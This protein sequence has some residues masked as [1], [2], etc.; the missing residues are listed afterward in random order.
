VERS[1][2][3]DRL[4]KIVGAPN[5]AITDA[6]SASFA[7]RAA[8]TFTLGFQRGGSRCLRPD[9]HRD[10]AQWRPD[11]TFKITASRLR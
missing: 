5:P 3:C 8:V 11:R 4:H 1:V 7:E 10:A 9:V 2:A 6:L